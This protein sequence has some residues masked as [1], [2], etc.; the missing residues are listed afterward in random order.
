MERSCAGR[1]EKGTVVSCNALGRWH[2]MDLVDS[3]YRG[4]VS[5]RVQSCDQRRAR[6]W[7]SGKVGQCGSVTKEQATM[8]LR[9]VKN[10][11]WPK[12]Y[13]CMWGRKMVHSSGSL[14]EVMAP[15]GRWGLTQSQYF[16]LSSR[17]L[18]LEK[19]TREGKGKGEK[20]IMSKWLS[21]GPRDPSLKTTTGMGLVGVCFL[22][23]N[24]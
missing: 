22:Q 11:Y 24:D 8:L 17:L 2:K 7:E 4:G 23:L 13:M 19:W 16:I 15:W 14:W 3:R 20:K 21:Q 10:H 6:G 18:H 5:S 1:W 9:K 12:S